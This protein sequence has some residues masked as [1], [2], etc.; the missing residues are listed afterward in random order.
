MHGA[1]KSAHEYREAMRLGQLRLLTA[2]VRRD[3]TGLW[4]AGMNVAAQSR[5]NEVSGTRC[6]GVRPDLARASSNEQAHINCIP[7]L[8]LLRLLALLCC[9]YVLPCDCANTGSR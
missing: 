4:G 5:P 6:A 1:A 3:Q 8:L 9:N 2:K 7:V